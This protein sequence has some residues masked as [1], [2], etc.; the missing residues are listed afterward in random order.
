MSLSCRVDTTSLISGACV[1]GNRGLGVLGI[2]VP[3]SGTHGAGYLYND[4]NL[5][6]ENADEFYGL[7]TSGPSGLTSFFA[8]EDS[9]FTAVGPDGSYSFTYTG[10]K[11]GTSYGS[12]T[13][14][15]SIGAATL[16]SADATHAHAADSLTL[17]TATVLAIAD[18]THAHGADSL[19]LTTASTL[20]VADATHSH[21]AD[22]ITLSGSGVASLTIADALHAHSADGLVLTTESALALQD[23]VHAHLADGITLSAGPE[24]LIAE[25]LHAHTSDGLVLT[26]A[27]WLVVA[28]ARHL[29][30][31]DSVVL[32]HSG[33]GGYTGTVGRTA[34][35]VVRIAIRAQARAAIR[36]IPPS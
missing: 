28:D 4:L 20:A 8:F 12:A 34:R 24:L 3:S 21:A 32:T 17:T 26:V 2:D 13:V 22:N 36:G 6:T 31:A 10:Y 9:S 30:A 5:P 16:A 35:P 14:S 15:F 33:S 27:A 11:N 23:A 19:A 18:A 7:I 25:G 29:H 1:V